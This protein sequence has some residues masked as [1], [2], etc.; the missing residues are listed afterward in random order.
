MPDQKMIKVVS[1]CASCKNIDRFEIPRLVME[2]RR[3]GVRLDDSSLG[4][5]PHRVVQLARHICRDC[6]EKKLGLP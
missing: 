1:K 5:D 6:Q 3:Q 2:K 4:L